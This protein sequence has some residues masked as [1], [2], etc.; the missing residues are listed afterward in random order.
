M[1]KL[2][3]DYIIVPKPSEGTYDI[4][5]KDM[6]TKTLTFHSNHVKK[7]EAIRE[8]DSLKGKPSQ[9]DAMKFMRDLKLQL[10][11]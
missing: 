5:E 11:N 9:S 6:R 2:H 8:L 4:F 7:D 10:T 3:V 1:V